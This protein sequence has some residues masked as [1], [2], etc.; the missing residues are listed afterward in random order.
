M[1]IL[2]GAGSFESLHTSLIF[3]PLLWNDDKVHIH[4]TPDLK[5]KKLSNNSSWDFEH[6]LD[7][8]DDYWVGPDK[9]LCPES[10]PNRWCC[11]HFSKKWSK[12]KSDFTLSIKKPVVTPKFCDRNF[13]RMHHFEDMKSLSAI[14][15]LYLSSSL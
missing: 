13:S 8:V 14:E 7:T 6:V 3:L 9:N 11:N 5:W 10:T 15:P 4:N 1:A 2:W 12:S